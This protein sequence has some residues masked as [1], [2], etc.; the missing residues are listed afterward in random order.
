MPICQVH[1]IPAH[2]DRI[3]SVVPHPTLPLLACATS[4]KSAQIYSLN[5]YFP[6]AQ[7]DGNHKRSIRSVSWKPKTGNSS[8]VVLATASFDGTVGIWI[9]DDDRYAQEVGSSGSVDDGADVG[10]E[11]WEFVA[12]LEGH[13]N[14][15]KCVDWSSDGAYLASCSRDKSVWIWEGKYCWNFL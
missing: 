12:S 1:S 4:D 2:T 15:V 11:E 9:R 6:V 14:E 13:E 7:L 8:E 5:T 3:W 10:L